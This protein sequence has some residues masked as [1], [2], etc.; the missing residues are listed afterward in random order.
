MGFYDC[1]CMATGV[2]LKGS[3][4]ALVLLQRASRGYR[5][6]ALAIKGS[7]NRF[8]SI[9]G[10]KEDANAALVLKYFRE[11]LRAGD[12]AIHEAYWREWEN[13]KV[14][15]VEQLLSGFE[16]N[17]NDRDDAAVMN[18][19]PVVFALI[20]QTVWD[21]LTR[22]GP[23]VGGSPTTWFGE[24]FDGVRVAEEIYR[25]SLTKVSQPLRELAAVAR[26]LADRGLRWKP[27]PSAGQHYRDDMR[28]HLSAA[29]RRFRDCEVMLDALL[30]YDREVEELLEDE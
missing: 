3:D 7:Y 30:Y 20:S 16:R 14:R 18:G 8:G 1:R 25:R 6:I 24:L 9:D 12:L 13:N 27:S 17:L 10:I 26:F 19:Q 11:R 21:T 4:A 15:D 22:S 28:R 23:Q 29:R 5:P 2:S